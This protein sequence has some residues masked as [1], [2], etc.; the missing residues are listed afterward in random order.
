MTQNSINTIP[1]FSVSVILTTF[2]RKKLVQRALQSVLK[3]TYCPDEI[4]LIDDGSNDGTD[5]I[6]SEIFSDIKYYK[7]PN[8]GVSAS[9]NLGIQQSTGN[10]IAFLDSDDEWLPKKLEKQITALTINPEYRICHTNE[11][12]IRKG[13]RVN[14]QKKHQKYGGQ[15]FEKC[16]PLCVISPS[17][18]LIHRQVFDQSGI[19]DTELP[20]CEDYDLWL[21]ICSIFS[22]LYIEE[23][24]I[25]KYGGH[26]DQLSH[27]YWG[28]DRFRI[29]ALENI[30]NNNNLDQK[31]RKAA[32]KMILTKIEIFL[33]GSK[34]RNN[35]DDIES[36][37]KKLLY[38][39]KQS[40]LI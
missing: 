14:P 15:I 25:V 30:I 33:N 17:S 6:I 19:F 26:E 39:Q 16:L 24:L 10:W 8:K 1:D 5:E 36:Y 13:R 2:N 32:I 37:K 12:W 34:K 22:V 18:V 23:P 38:F 20:A 40:K 11:I 28:M 4:I 3:Q 21:R 27:K 29:Y 35:K 7:Q 31:Q 9:R